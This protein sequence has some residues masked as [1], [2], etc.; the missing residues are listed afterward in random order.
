M[1]LNLPQQSKTD[2]DVLCTSYP[3][4]SNATVMPY[5]I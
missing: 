4:D 5:D 3:V 1:K 2:A